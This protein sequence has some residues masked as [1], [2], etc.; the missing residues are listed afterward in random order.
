MKTRSFV[1]ILALLTGATVA[2]AQHKERRV[3]VA[4]V[5]EPHL[6]WMHA[7][8]ARLANGPVR[9][10]FGAGLRLDYRFAKYYA[11][12]A[13]AN[14]NVTGGNII[15]SDPFILRLPS[16][17]DIL[18]ANTRV[19]YRLRYVEIPIALKIILP[20]VGYSTWF[21]EAGIDPMFNTRSQINATDNNIEGVSFE[22][23]VAPFDL[24]WHSGIGLRYSLGSH[25]SWQIALVYKNTFLDVTREEGIRQPDNVRIN[26]V[27]LNLALVL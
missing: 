7:D 16:G 3:S 8:E 12:S 20:E 22:R 4:A 1:I 19:T 17:T 5:I 15:Y 26:Q 10:G 14:W 6:N 23:G 9:A 2:Q 13:G 25:L 24:A 11:F 18:Q 21:F 27:G